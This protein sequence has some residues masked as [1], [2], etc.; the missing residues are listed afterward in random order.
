M[1]GQRSRVCVLH[2]QIRSVNSS[3]AKCLSPFV[4]LW[5]S[6]KLAN[7]RIVVDEGCRSVRRIAAILEQPYLPLAL[8]LSPDLEDRTLESLRRESSF[9]RASMTYTEQLERDIPYIGRVDLRIASQAY[10]AGALWA[11]RMSLPGG[12]VG[13]G[14]LK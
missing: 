6:E 12:T 10:R 9:L 1:T 3:I 13:K 5:R 4:E 8:R 11:L 14:H 2:G 7:L